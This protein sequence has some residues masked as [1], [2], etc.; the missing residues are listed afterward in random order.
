MK[1]VVNTN[2]NTCRIYHYAKRPVELKLVKE[3][4]HLEGKLK[5]ADLTSDKSG[6]YKV[7]SSARGAYSPHTDAKEHEIDNFSREIA[8]ELNK[9]RINHEYDELIVIAPPHMDGL[10]FQ[11]INKHVKDMV[12]NNIKKDLLHLSHND[13]LDFLQTNT[14]YHDQK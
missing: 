14:R 4:T 9:E 3:I 6:H 12:I 13:L 2:T 10:L 11:H 7:D 1:L 8:N 5:N